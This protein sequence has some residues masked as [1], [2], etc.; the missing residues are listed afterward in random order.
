MNKLAIKTIEKLQ[1]QQMEIIIPKEII[2]S[3]KIKIEN[4]ENNNLRDLLDLNKSNLSTSKKCL[5][6][7]IRSKQSQRKIFVRLIII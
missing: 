3:E 6:I 5:T 7:N 4:N 1:N 2:K